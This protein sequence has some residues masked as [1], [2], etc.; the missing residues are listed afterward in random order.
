VIVHGKAG[1]Y[2]SKITQCAA[3]LHHQCVFS[4][5]AHCA[6][7]EIGLVATPA[8]KR[9]GGGWGWGG[10]GGLGVR[11]TSSCAATFGQTGLIVSRKVP[12]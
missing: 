11:L 3:I 8:R 7:F 2:A 4:R 1:S 6:N 5:A 12:E 10:G 9:W